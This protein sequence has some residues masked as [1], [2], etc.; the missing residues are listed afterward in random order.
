MTIEIGHVEAIFRY[1]VKSMRGEQLD[2]AL[3]GWHGIEGDRRLAFRRIEDQGGFPWLTASKFPD[4]ICFTPL[5]GEGNDSL[6]TQV[7]TPDGREF[8]VFGEPLAEEVKRRHGAPVQMTHLRQGIFDDASVSLISS[9]T[10][11]EI[12][13]IAKRNLNARRFRPNIVIRS[14]RAI[15][16]EEDEWLGG[17]LTFGAADNAPA[18]SV[19]MRD[20]RCAMVN[21]DPE[22]GSI[23]TD[24]MKACVRGNQNYAGVYGAVT[25][26]G[27]L[28]AGQA[29]IFHPNPLSLN[30][31]PEMRKQNQEKGLPKSL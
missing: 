3:L 7:R 9:A 5:R 18:V 1:P 30:S 2:S 20:L 16:F 17:V 22:D 11:G 28:S 23:N 27:R 25:K 13:Q 15:P 31:H 8:A 10:I 14:N 24:V 21:I 29:V 19:T 6:P 4:L 12:G 26:V